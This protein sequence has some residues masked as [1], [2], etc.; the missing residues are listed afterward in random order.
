MSI[1]QESYKNL[2]LRRFLVFFEKPTV[3]WREERNWRQ[4]FASFTRLKTTHNLAQ[5]QKFH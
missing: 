1:L 5:F 4:V 2:T 3:F